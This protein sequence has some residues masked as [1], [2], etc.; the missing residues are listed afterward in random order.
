MPKTFHGSISV[1]PYDD[2]TKIMPWSLVFVVGIVTLLHRSWKIVLIS[3]I[4]IVNTGVVN[5]T[6]TATNSGGSSTTYFEMAVNGTGL[7]IFYP[8]D[9][10]NL[11]IKFNKNSWSPFLK[12]FSI[13]MVSRY[14]ENSKLISKLGK[15]S[16]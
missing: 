8:Y 3:G 16:I 15:V 12:T 10:L 5:Y 6:I 1:D 2:L 14:L 4:P 9:E 11:A 13:N 7:Y